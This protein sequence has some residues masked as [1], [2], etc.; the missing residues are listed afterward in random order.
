MQLA[1]KVEHNTRPLD[2]V[3]IVGALHNRQRICPTPSPTNKI[4]F[5]GGKISYPVRCSTC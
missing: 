4:C 2:V 1:L 5:G 3:S